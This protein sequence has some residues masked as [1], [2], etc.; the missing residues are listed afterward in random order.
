VYEVYPTQEAMLAGVLEIA[1]EIADKSPLAIWGT[2]QM[3]NY[4]RDHSVEDGLEYVATW[5]AG[6]FFGTDMAEAFR[7][8]AEKR[9]PVFSNNPPSRRGDR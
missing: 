1:R 5:Q 9:K 8:K 6:M 3:L 2:K 4:A 7:A